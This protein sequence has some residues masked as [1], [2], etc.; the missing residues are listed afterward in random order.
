MRINVKFASDRKSETLMYKPKYF[1]AS[2]GS[3]TEVKYF[4]S[5]NNSVISKNV[6]IIN[7]LRDYA[8]LTNS[9]P[10]FIMKMIKEFLLNA[11][12][13]KISA[14][15]LKNKISNFLHDNYLLVEQERVFKVIENTY[16]NDSELIPKE[17]IE[18]LLIAL[19]KEEIYKEVIQ[20]FS[21]YFKTQDVTYSELT[22]KIN[23]EI[24]RDKQNFKEYQYDEIVEY[25]KANSVDLFVSNPTFEFWLLLHF[26][27]IENEDRQKMFE[28]KYVTHSKRYL[29]KR[30]NQICNYNK[31]NLIFSFFEPF[32]NDAIK[33]EKDF[34]EDINELKNNLGSNV[35][36]LINSII[37]EKY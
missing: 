3:G 8:K 30:L 6:T 14:L 12:E 1:I 22:D 36:V 25:C 35:G 7:I 13:N 19:F 23:I 17:K 21:I 16:K 10:T 15:E 11:K 24:D 33:R 5:L 29:E 31:S 20:N 32:I 18:A 9:H 26:K 4:T 2:E 27:E 37:N 34:A 28:N